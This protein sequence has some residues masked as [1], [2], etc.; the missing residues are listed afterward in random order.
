MQTFIARVLNN[1]VLLSDE[2]ID[3]FVEEWHTHEGWRN[4]ELHSALG[5]SFKEYE[6]SLTNGL[7]NTIKQALSTN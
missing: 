3:D 1:S 7:L 2:A 4:Q 6:L 5:L